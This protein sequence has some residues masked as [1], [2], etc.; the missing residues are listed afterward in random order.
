MYVHAVILE[1]FIGCNLEVAAG[2]AGCVV[3]AANFILHL[4]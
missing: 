4:I 2:L 3:R 1:K